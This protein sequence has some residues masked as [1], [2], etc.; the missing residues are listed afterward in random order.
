MPVRR[1][2]RIIRRIDPWTVLKVSLVFNAIAALAFVL[3]SVIFWSVF[4]NGKPAK[5][6]RT[7][8][9]PG[10]DDNQVLIRMI[11]SA[12]AFPVEIV[13][14]T[15]AGALGFFGAIGLNLPRPDMVVTNTRW[16]LFLPQGPDYRAPGSN[17]D[18][19]QPGRP[20]N[21]EVVAKLALARTADALESY[22]Q[23]L[24]I[25]VPQRGIHFAFEKLYATQA[26]E[27]PYVRIGYTSASGYRLGEMLGLVGIVLAL[28][29][30]NFRRLT[31]NL[32]T[33]DGN[34]AMRRSATL[35]LVVG[36]LSFRKAL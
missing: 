31:P 11:N 1:V 21:P 23:P 17:M 16:D 34:E 5:P 3:G 33:G 28:G 6:A 9:P 12:N 8:F 19:L 29:A 35:E 10:E 36:E 24:R 20:V 13:Y 14:A 25:N 4:V 22:G 32:G 26:P 7:D 15:P 30:R 2:R 18:L 27:D